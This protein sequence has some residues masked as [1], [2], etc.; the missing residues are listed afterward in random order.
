MKRELATPEAKKTYRASADCIGGRITAV[1]GKTYALADRW[2]HSDI[3]G[4]R[5]RWR[6]ASGKIVGRDNASGGLGIAQQW[7]VLCPE[8]K[9]AGSAAKTA[10]APRPVQQAPAARFNV[11]QIV[12]AR[13]GREWIRGRVT[14]I[15]QVR[16]AK[17]PELAYDVRQA[18]HT[19]RAYAAQS[20]RRIVA[21]CARER[22]NKKYYLKLICY[23]PSLLSQYTARNR[24]Q[25]GKPAAGSRGF[26]IRDT[27]VVCKTQV[28]VRNCSAI[29]AA[30]S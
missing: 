9:K 28:V 5:T 8:T 14:R 27:M 16:G 2:D 18:R 26:T 7:E 6:D 22:I 12:E 19:A 1:D 23:E 3:G 24:N 25:H 30:R 4:G 11:G 29:S 15:S 10:A 17:G 21:L 13:Y 20:L